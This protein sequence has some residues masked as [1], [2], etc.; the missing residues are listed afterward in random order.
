MRLMLYLLLKLLRRPKLNNRVEIEKGIDLEAGDCVIVIK[1]NG[2]I[3]E[4]FLPEIN[5]PAKE[6]KG[7]KLTMNIL[8]FAD[9]KSGELIR[10][11]ANK[12]RYN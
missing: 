12:K 8:E 6:T 1:E 5:N 11:A 2:K 9:K 7:Y 10:A 3:G 4:V